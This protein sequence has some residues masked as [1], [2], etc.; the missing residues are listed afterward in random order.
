MKSLLL[1]ACFFPPVGSM[2]IPG[3][4][5]A[6]RFLRYSDI[7]ELHVLTVKPGS[8]P[9]YLDI[10]NS[11]SLPINGEKV[12]RTGVFDLFGMLLRIRNTIR[13]VTRKLG[14]PGGRVESNFQ[15]ALSSSEQ[16]EPSG[17][18][19]LVSAL[20]TYPDFASPWLIPA[21]VKGVKIIRENRIE[22]ILAT[23]MPWTSLLIG[24]FLKILTGAKLIVDFRDPWVGNPFHNKNVLVRHLDRGLESLVVNGSDLVIANTEPLRKDMASKYP[25]IRE[26]LM[27]VPNG[28]DT[29]D[30]DKIPHF[31]FPGSRFVITHA[32]LLYS[33]RDPIAFL[34][35]IEH[36]KKERPEIASQ[37]H[38]VQIGGTDYDLGYDPR[39]VC[40]QKGISDNVTILDYM[41]HE[42]CL[43][44][45][46]ASDALLVIQPDTRTQIPSKIYEY[47]Y[48]EKPI[49]TIAEKH[50]A[51]GALVSE[52]GFGSVFEPCEPQRIA[53]Y[54]IEL[55]LKKQ[56]G[57]SAKP[58]YHLKSK[59]DARFILSELKLRLAAL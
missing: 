25:N 3:V 33:R 10:D 23:G 51:L 48:L 24:Y 47:V 5:R 21:I 50:G 39:E 9:T 45:L 37:V 53:G 42:E 26:K 12:Y 28:Y 6:K 27:V 55:V 4:Q 14:D 57:E 18:T 36:L 49:L 7:R 20:L 40:K 8:Y 22:A 11:N 44:H 34:D 16:A 32:G 41:K 17:L 38:F 29:E 58:D 30:F 19:D 54:L 13:S 35:A 59:F 15:P 2:G 43:G 46:A 56:R 1:I 52:H 31:S